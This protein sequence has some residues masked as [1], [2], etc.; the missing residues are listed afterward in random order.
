MDCSLYFVKLYK[1]LILKKNLVVLQY[2]YHKDKQYRSIPDVQK[3]LFNG[4]LML[5]V[6]QETNRVK[7]VRSKIIYILL[8]YYIL[9]DQI[10]FKEV[11]S[12]SYLAFLQ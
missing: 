9:F 4:C 8:G 6:V 2:Y 11:I 12:Y 3:Y 1:L 5:E 10:T 7:E